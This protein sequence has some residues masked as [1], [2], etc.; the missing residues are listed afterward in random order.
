MN[1]KKEF[2]INQGHGDHNDCIC[3][4]G[5]SKEFFSTWIPKSISEGELIA[6]TEE[7]VLYNSGDGKSEKNRL[8]ILAIRKA[9]CG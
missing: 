5:M 3:E 9:R 4:P 6:L 2:D 8:R 7:K 1:D